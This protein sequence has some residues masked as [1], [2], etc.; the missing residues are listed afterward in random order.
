MSI[1]VVTLFKFKITTIDYLS[2]V[3]SR[4]AVYYLNKQWP[5][6]PDARVRPLDNIQFNHMF[7]FNMFN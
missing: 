4:H 3:L 5:P 7:C 6:Q 2:N 1:Y